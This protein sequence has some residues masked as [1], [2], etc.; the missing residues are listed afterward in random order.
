MLHIHSSYN[1][2]LFMVHW[3]MMTTL[4]GSSAP[5]GGTTHVTPLGVRVV[6]A[7]M[8]SP[9]VYAVALGGRSKRAYHSKSEGWGASVAVKTN[10]GT[11]PSGAACTRA[12]EV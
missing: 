8:P 11:P 9:S 12:M 2:P 4:W 7:G 10:R 1:L 3:G 6:P 5:P